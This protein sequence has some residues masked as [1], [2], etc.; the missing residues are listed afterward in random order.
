MIVAF[1][2]YVAVISPLFPDRHHL[3]LRPL[4]AL[5]AIC[6][7]LLAIAALDRGHRAT[8]VGTLRDWL[9]LLFTLLAFREME[10]FLPRAF[11]GRLEAGWIQLD[12]LLLD[13]HHIRSAIESFGVA[14]PLYL[15]L[16]YFLVY[17]VA[18]A[19]VGI[20]YARGKRAWVDRFWIVNLTG[21]LVAYALFPYFPS[22]PPRIV[23]AGLDNPSIVTW[24]RT[25]NLFIL[26][27]ASIHA[28]VFPSAHVSSAFACA[29]AMLLLLPERRRIG[30]GLLIY[31]FSVSIATVYGRYHY[32]ADVVAGFAVSLVAL[33]LGLV[34]KQTKRPRALPAA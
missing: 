31:A 29:W 22:Q 15:E 3:G 28:G 1:F 7:A 24:V 2:V 32:A 30:F 10:L 8:V 27:H 26:N 16:C 4:A 9:P 11:E 33:S 13:R 5:I 20:L 17:G 25:L 6:T 14:I 19:C 34:L 21:T 18:A 23:F 12:R